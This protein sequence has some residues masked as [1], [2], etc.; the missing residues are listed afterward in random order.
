MMVNA[1]ASTIG[2][3]SAAEL[4][5]KGIG[6]ISTV[7]AVI[8]NTETVK[9]RY[10]NDRMRVDFRLRDSSQTIRAQS[11]GYN[12]ELSD[13]FERSRKEKE[14]TE[15]ELDGQLVVAIADIEVKHAVNPDGKTA[16]DL[17]SFTHAGLMLF[18]EAFVDESDSLNT[19][20]HG[21]IRIPA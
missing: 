14:R 9:D 8:S 5:N 6:S 2:I 1:N 18:S 4:E 19:D 3:S 7:K 15:K 20:E 21:L 10:G 16:L 11:F 17:V 12:Q 13:Q